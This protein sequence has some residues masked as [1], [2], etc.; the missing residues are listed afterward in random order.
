MFMNSQLIGSVLRSLRDLEASLVRVKQL[1]ALEH[2]YAASVPKVLASRSRVA[3]EREGTVVIAADNSAIAAKLRHLA[4]RI[5]LEIV[6][7]V[8]EVTAIRVEVQ[9]AQAPAVRR[10]PSAEIGP[11]GLASLCELRDSL[12]V[13]PLKAAL[14]RLVSRREG[15]NRQDQALQGKEGE[16]D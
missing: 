14:N 13:S 8:P 4:P 7:S 10:E 3:Y 1:A 9:V 12:P 16:N 6:K 2:L 5:V 11:K 15:L